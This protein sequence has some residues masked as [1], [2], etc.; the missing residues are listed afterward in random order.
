[1]RDEVT[2]YRNYIKPSA[3][4][5][6]R[7]HTNVTNTSSGISRESGRNINVKTNIYLGSQG[8]NDLQSPKIMN[9]APNL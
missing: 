4:D 9:I 3:T 2:D 7:D 8:V 1:M 5:D 6:H